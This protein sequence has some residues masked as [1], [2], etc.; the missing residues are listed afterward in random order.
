MRSRWD[1]KII[2]QNLE[3]VSLIRASKIVCVFQ[4]NFFS[5]KVRARAKTK[6]KPEKI[7][8]VNLPEHY[9]CNACSFHNN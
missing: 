1:G 7:H 5:E 8:K 4:V 6:N 2:N 9:C 3:L